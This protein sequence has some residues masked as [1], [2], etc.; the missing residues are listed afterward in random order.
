MRAF[1]YVTTYVDKIL[2]EFLQKKF[3][4]AD[5]FKNE[6]HWPSF[7]GVAKNCAVSIILL[8]FWG[9]STPTVKN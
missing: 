1:S 8:L 2:L 7:L 4:S 6:V 3:G 5:V 9:F